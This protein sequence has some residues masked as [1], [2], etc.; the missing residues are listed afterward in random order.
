MSANTTTQSDL[1]RIVYRR[2]LRP[3]FNLRS[4]LLQRF[5]RDT[6]NWA[7]GT[8]ISIP[9]HWAQSGGFGW[10]D[11]G[12]LPTPG[13]QTVK[14]AIFDY[15]K[16]YGRIRI[17]GQHMRRARRSYAA[18]AQPFTFEARGLVQDIRSGL[19]KDLWGNGDGSLAVVASGVSANSITV[20]DTYGLQNNA[21]VDVLLK[22][23]GVVGSGVAGARINITQATKTVTLQSGNFID[24]TDIQANPTNYKVYRQ[25]S[26]NQA[27]FGLDAIISTSNPTAGNYGGLDRDLTV[28]DPWKSF[29][30]DNAGVLRQISFRKIQDAIDEVEWRSPGQTNLIIC[31][32]DIWSVIA[33]RLVNDKFYRG[34]TMK[35]NG[36]AQ[37]VDFAGIPIVKDKH[38]TKNTIYGLDTTF[39]KIYQSSEG[40]W[41]DYSGSVLQAVPGMDEY[42]ANWVRELQCVCLAPNAQWRINDV[43]PQQ[44]AE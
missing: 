26:Y 12:V 36:W 2:Y 20:E 16:L 24:W 42:E 19:N 6:E 41:I 28:N 4:I 31:P 1:L 13:E 18:E 33:E 40:E 9:L 10:S 43:D 5:G 17:A 38:C 44:V 35:L 30:D 32:P 25:G 21:I 14:R 7:Q 27:M 8:N 39:F 23:T 29:V 11:A 34:E 15:G 22:A 37:A 3:M